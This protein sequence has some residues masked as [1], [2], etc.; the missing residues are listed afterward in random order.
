LEAALARE[1]SDD[2]MGAWT[3]PFGRGNE[4]STFRR[5]RRRHDQ[6]AKK[7]KLDHTARRAS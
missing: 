4:A 3:C 5:R 1:E 6:A 2:S 7:K